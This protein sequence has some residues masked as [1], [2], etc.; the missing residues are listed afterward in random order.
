MRNQGENAG[1]QGD[2]NVESQCGN[3]R[4]QDDSL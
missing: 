2:G 3:A 4:N 1:N